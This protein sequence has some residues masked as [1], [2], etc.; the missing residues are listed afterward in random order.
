MGMSVSTKLQ[1][2]LEAGLITADQK[3]RILDHE[4]THST[5]TWRNG[6]MNVGLLSI[7]LG[8]AL[9][10]GSNWQI[11]PW[12]CKIGLHLL[13]NALLTALVWRWRNEPARDTPREIALGA[14]WGLTLTFIA[15]MG[16]VFQLGGEAYVAVRIWF[17]LTTP[18]VLLFAQSRA[19]AR[20]WAIAFVFYVPYDILSF[21]VD[22]VKDET[23][24]QSVA[25]C[26]AVLLPIIAWSI[27]A[28]PRVAVN[29]PT[30]GRMLR[31]LGIVLALASA[32]AASLN[33]YDLH[34]HNNVAIAVALAIVAILTRFVL[35]ARYSDDMDRANIDVLALAGIFTCVPFIMPVH[36]DVCAIIDFI[37]LCLLVGALYQQQGHSRRVSLAI[38]FITMRLCVAFIELFGTMLMSGFGFIIAGIVL[39]A[40]VRL[41]KHL[42]RLL[43]LKIRSEQ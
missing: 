36:S 2:W 43:K 7:L 38:S 35:R 6:V 42:D 16:Q 13:V 40:L 26:L 10:I 9:V 17:W 14:L 4:K 33:F 5:N 25:L 23:V 31:R 34:T 39:L 8:I 20:I 21:T 41:G 18:M 3:T 15:L 19:L 37:A 29:R 22:H 32:G 11:I 28:I 30:I 12:Q 24:Q 27:G 1:K